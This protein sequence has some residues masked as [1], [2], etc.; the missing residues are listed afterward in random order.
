MSGTV[1]DHYLPHGDTGDSED[2]GWEEVKHVGLMRS[3][4]R[5]HYLPQG[6]TGDSEDVAREVVSHV[7]LM[8]Q[9]RGEPVRDEIYVMQMYCETGWKALRAYDGT[10]WSEFGSIGGNP[11]Q[12]L[13]DDDMPPLESC[14]D[15]QSVGG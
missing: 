12:M 15:H 9:I 5:D 14:D 2:A 3:T 6:V 10:S 4:M 8:R 1:R 11:V 13:N 7:N